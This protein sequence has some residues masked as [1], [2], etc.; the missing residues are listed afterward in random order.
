MNENPP[1]NGW[2][3]LKGLDV[4]LNACSQ[5]DYQSFGIFHFLL[6]YCETNFVFGCSRAIVL[7]SAS[8]S[9]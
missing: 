5:I 1:Y 7:C 6:Q 9:S 4:W 8:K 2:C 3:F